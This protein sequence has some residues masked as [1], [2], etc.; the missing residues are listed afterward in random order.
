[1]KHEKQLALFLV[2]LIIYFSL[3]SCVYDIK[4]LN[5]FKC[6]GITKLNKAI[7]LNEKNR[8]ECFSLNGNECATFSNDRSCRQFLD[9]NMSRVV[10]VKC[11]S[12]NRNGSGSPSWCSEAERFYF[13]RWLC[14]EETGIKTGIRL[15]R[16]GNVQCLS[17]NGRDCVW[18]N[19]GNK[20]CRKIKYC[21]RTQRMM[22]QL[23]CGS[24][25]FKKVWGHNGYLFA[26]DHWCKKG[27]AFYFYTGN[28]LCRQSTG[29]STPIRLAINGDMECLSKNRKDCIRGVKSNC[30][31]NRL[32]TKYRSKTSQL[33]CGK[34][35][36]KIYRM[37]GYRKRSH[38]CRRSHDMVYKKLISLHYIANKNCG[39]QQSFRREERRFISHRK[40]FSRSYNQ[41]KNV[42]R[43]QT[44]GRI[45]RYVRRQPIRTSHHHIQKTRQTYGRIQRYFRRKPIR[46]SLHRIQKMR[47]TYGPRWKKIL[48]GR[49]G[50][51]W[52]LRAKHGR[53]WKVVLR[54]RYGS[55]WRSTC[56][57]KYILKR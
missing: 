33:R 57:K 10:P 49:Y 2:V 14:Y 27:F 28:F 43:R 13:N 44:F 52:K 56:E 12:G 23:T 24:Q 37:S 4:R 34:N 15:S 7:R 38:W 35:H 40:R 45:Q 51:M 3:G 17:K 30:Q 25:K 50:K 21:R 5:G 6:P 55:N 36:K 32:I 31:C 9:N 19:Y 29:M 20:V 47:Y 42:F 46:I 41:T 26:Y 1:M 48:K 16:N 8:V 18:G 53:N 22:R 54:N 11:G 39:Y